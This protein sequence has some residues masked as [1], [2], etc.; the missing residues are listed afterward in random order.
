M[1]KKL[2]DLCD[3]Y[4]ITYVTIS[5]R[6]ALLAY[7]D[8]LLAIGDGK[9]GFTLSH[10]EREVHAVAVGQLTAASIVDKDTEGRIKSHLTA[11]SQPYANLQQP[12][13]L[14]ERSNRE[15]FA[16][17][18]QLGRPDNI[19]KQLAGMVAFFGAQIYLSEF[20]NYNEGRMYGALMSQDRRLMLSLLGRATGCAFVL[21]WVIETFL[22]I[23]KEIAAT[24]S[25]RITTRLQ[26]RYINNSM[27]YRLHY[28]DQR[29]KDADQRLAEDVRQF[30][31]AFTDLAIWM[32]RPFNIVVWDTFR[33]ATFFN[34][35]VPVAMMGYFALAAITLKIAAPDYKEL[36]RELSRLE[37]RFSFVHARTKSCAESIAFFGGDDKEKTIVS[38]RFEELMTHDWLRNW[39]NFKFR[40][41]EDVFQS[42]LP[43]LIQWIV[44]FSYG[45]LYFTDAQIIADK[46]AAMYQGQVQ[47][48]S[49]SSSLFG[50][51]G[52]ILRMS[53][54]PFATLTG[55]PPPPPQKKTKQTLDFFFNSS[56]RGNSQKR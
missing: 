54:E 5:H 10:I 12:R 16:R 19:A 46:G 8:Q 50:H 9:C 28:L 13:K 38:Q 25:E 43:D 52:I 56:A 29:I 27:Y 37:G 36:W 2:Y 3:A 39:V 26:E 11:R 7:H 48:A 6:P 30:G 14:P 17:L 23:Q 18:W 20:R 33:L 40:I 24:M 41:V 4:G 55:A 15:R 31:D 1:E 49:L 32:W 42:R 53:G 21:A 51:M 22:Y 35:K 34:W 45:R 47:L 44:R